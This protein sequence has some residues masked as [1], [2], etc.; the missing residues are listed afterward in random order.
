MVRKIMKDSTS[1]VLSSKIIMTASILNC[2]ELS[3][4][5]CRIIS[6]LGTTFPVRRCQCLTLGPHSHHSLSL[7][8]PWWF[9]TEFQSL[10]GSLY[11]IHTITSL[12]S[13]Q[14]WHIQWVVVTKT[15]T[16]TMTSSQE[17][18]KISLH[19]FLWLPRLSSRT[20][21][22]LILTGSRGDFNKMT[23]RPRLRGK[24]SREKRHPRTI[25]SL[26]VQ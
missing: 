23:K 17:V 2:Q 11:T 9:R 20:T 6:N 10:A 22:I 15:F 26:L 14:W 1:K 5:T 13:T 19:H 7:H 24:P 4:K 18:S 25:F 21:P 12:P 16:V 3:Y 8:T